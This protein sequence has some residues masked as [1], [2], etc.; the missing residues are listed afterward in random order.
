MGA[1]LLVI[2]AKYKAQHDLQGHAA[3]V[4]RDVYTFVPLCRRLPFLEESGVDRYNHF[5]QGRDLFLIEGRLYHPSLPLPEFP[6]AHHQAIAEEQRDTFDI[7]TFHIVLPVLYQHM[8][9]K[10]DVPGHISIK[11][12]YRG[13]ID[14]AVDLELTTHP[15]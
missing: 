1:S 3:R 2:F 12:S 10:L 8:L 15:L 5:K 13:L 7:L 9:G 6:L 14:I 4:V 11:S